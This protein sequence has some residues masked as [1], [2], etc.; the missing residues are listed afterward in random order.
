MAALALVGAILGFLFLSLCSFLSFWNTLAMG[1]VA[2]LWF[3]NFS[4]IFLP[5]L[6]LDLSVL[7]V[8]MPSQGPELYLDWLAPLPSFPCFSA[9]GLTSSSWYW[10]FLHPSFFGVLGK[11]FL[12]FS[13]G[14]LFLSTFEIL[15]SGLVF[16]VEVCLGWG[17]SFMLGWGLGPFSLVLR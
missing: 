15:L 4:G 2:M 9:F 14:L 6:R 10:D 8:G 3:W 13:S 12:S 17:F 7:G 5:S 11:S 1:M 16:G